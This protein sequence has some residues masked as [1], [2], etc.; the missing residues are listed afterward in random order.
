VNIPKR[1]GEPDCTFA[2]IKKI[3]QVLSWQP[4]VSFEKGVRIMLE[5]MNHWQ[6]APIWDEKSIAEATKDW[7]A[8]LGSSPKR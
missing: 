8:Y 4:K 3:S 1:P 6:D 2:D 7:F 5:N